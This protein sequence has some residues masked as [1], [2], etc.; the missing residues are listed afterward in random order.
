V[1][2]APGATHAQAEEDLPDRVELL[3]DHVDGELFLVGRA[4]A[5]GADDEESGGH[6]IL[7]PLALVASG[8][9]IP[10]QLLRDEPV[11][12]LVG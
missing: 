10:G 9:E 7:V 4:D 11:E 2:V 5:L 8:E 12:G 6:E 1:V 3:V